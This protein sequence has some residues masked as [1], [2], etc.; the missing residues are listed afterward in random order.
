[1]LTRPRSTTAGLIA[2]TLAALAAALPAQRRAVTY[3]DRA[4]QALSGFAD[5]PAKSAMLDLVDFCIER[6]Y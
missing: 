1:M 5:N 6:I 3:A 2:L 4:K